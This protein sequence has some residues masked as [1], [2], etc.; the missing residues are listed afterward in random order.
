ML[1]FGLAI[2]VLLVKQYIFSSFLE[3]KISL[4]VMYEHLPQYSVSVIRAAQQTSFNDR[5]KIFHS[6]RRMQFLQQL[7]IFFKKI[8]QI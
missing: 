3:K 1:C 4:F 5:E 2:S 8:A 7:F 6:N